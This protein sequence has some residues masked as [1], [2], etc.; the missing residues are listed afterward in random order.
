MGEMA[1]MVLGGNRVSSKK[2]ESAGF[3]YKYNYIGEAL[4][5]IL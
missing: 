2:I 1:S 5:E 4:D 3:K